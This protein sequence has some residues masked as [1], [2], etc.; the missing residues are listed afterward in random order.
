M[1]P[2]GSR[3]SKIR[4]PRKSLVSSS[5]E[6]SSEPL[7]DF[8]KSWPILAN[9]ITQIQQKNVSNLSYEQL[10]RKA[11]VLVLRKFGAKLYDNVAALITQ[12]LL[13]RREYLLSIKDGIEEF[14]KSILLEWNEHLQAMKF[15]SDVLMYLNRVYVKENK[16]LLI[17]DLG[18]Q[19]FK[20]HIIKHG[21]DEVGKKIIDIIITEIT[22]N[23]N[24]EVITSNMYISKL[25]NMLQLLIETSNSDLHYGESYYQSV[26][27]P[28]FL[29]SSETFFYKLSQDFVNYT[30]GTKFLHE[31][32]Q[33]IKDEENRVNFYLPSS[34]YP[35]LIDLMNNIIIKDK[36]D[37]IISLPFEYQ[38]LSFWLLPVIDNIFQE[39]NEQHKIN[40]LKLLYELIGRIDDE[41]ALLRM[42]LKEIIV[43]QGKRIPGFVRNSLEAAS[44]S[45]KKSSSPA[46]FATKWIDTVLEYHSQIM[47][48]L[49]TS[50][51]LNPM[52]E[53]TINYAIRDFINDSGT[54]VSKKSSSNHVDASEMLSIYMDYHIK[55]FSKAVSSKDSSNSNSPD[56]SDELIAKSIAFL[57]SIKDKDSFEA[58]YAN[59]FAKRFLN[60]KGNSQ[61]VT[62]N[63][64]LGVDL[65]ELVL[66]KLVEEMGSSSLSKVL[67][68]NKDIK[69]SR[70][71]TNDWKRYI[72]KNQKT[73]LVELDLKIC[74][75]TDWPKSMTKDYKSF[76][77]PTGNE[78]SLIWSRQLRPT[79]KEFEEFWFAG[80]KNHNKSLFWSPKFGSMDFRITY[81]SRTYE[82]NMPT[83]AGLIMLLFAPQSSDPEVLAFDEKRELTYVEIQELTGIPES[84]LKRHLQSIAVAPR[85]RLLIKIPMSKEV[86]SS[87]VFKLNE[88]F[89]SPSVKVKVL[90]VSASSS[91]PKEKV[92]KTEQEEEAEEVKNNIQEGRKH[93]VNAA[94]VRI[95]KSRHLLK[96]N[97]LF[98]ELVKQLASRFQPL[99][100]LI[101]QR[102]EDLI[103]KEY[104][105]RDE[106]NRN[107]YH[108]VA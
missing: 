94:I 8:E 27:E 30:N 3:R 68:M 61:A 12:H 38:G 76:S 56:D 37:Q 31:A 32:S 57:R 43:Q 2:P 7:A 52:V 55:Q 40:E 107:I 96:H 74:N 48:I 24:G 54:G 97:E 41:Y 13:Q 67:R 58:N 82:F 29:A 18:I 106:E 9:A 104:L 17:Y 25:I 51:D 87:D 36:I 83:Y 65:E 45:T 49:N 44:A 73:D 100:P 92:Q 5:L 16:K 77:N 19:L 53:A 60:A 66:S 14:M 91:A 26:F 62:S 78:Q 70:D 35:K 1:L 81:P 99:I 105:K 6:N 20:D 101:K 69:L 59:H 33:F 42:R 72:I 11:Y 21:N 93:E 15:I 75:V 86:N 47:S 85:L 84:D 88:K 10:Y 80:K 90:T 102:I 23:R 108:Y 34:T 71:M 64:K 28:E 22:R 79:I 98:E 4:P 46:S 103:E 95:M 89:K 39:E 63:N 50:F